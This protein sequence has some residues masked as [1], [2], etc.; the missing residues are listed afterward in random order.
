MKRMKMCQRKSHQRNSW[1]S[2]NFESVQGMMLEA[3]PNL[4]RNMTTVGGKEKILYIMLYKEKK[5]VQ[6]TLGNCYSK[7]K[8]IL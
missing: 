5:H 7:E 3:G 6:T 1:I 4:K 8:K 2:H